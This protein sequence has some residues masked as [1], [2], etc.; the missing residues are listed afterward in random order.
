MQ[1]RKDQVQAY[2]FVVGRLAAAVTHGRP[3]VLQPPNKR[4]NSGVVLGFMLAAV[5]AGIFGVYG[6]FVP[7][8]DNT[9]QSQ[10]AIVMDESTG[11]RY[12]YLDGQLRPVLNYSSARLASGNAG[13][14][15]VI[16]VSRNSLKNTPI[17]QPIGIP[18]APDALPDSGKLVDPA[19]TECIQPGGTVTLL[20]GE[21][22]DKPDV[23]AAHGIVVATPD[24]GVYL[25]WQG[26]RY[27]VGERTVLETLGYGAVRPVPVVPSWLNPIPAGPDI[28]L[29][30]VPG[31]GTSGPV[32][33]GRPSRVGQVYKIHNAALGFDQLYLVG[34]DA[35]SSL[36]RTG[37]ALVLASPAAK[38]AYRDA[39]VRPIEAGPG[40][41]SG[42]PV[43]AGP[44][45]AAGLPADP[46]QIVTPSQTDS[47]CVSFMPSEHSAMSAAVE[48][49]PAS[50]VAARSVPAAAHRAGET[51]DRVGVPAGAGVLAKELLAPG[52]VPGTLYLVTEVGI[53]FPLAD[54][55]VAGSLGYPA[56]SAVLVPRELLDLLPTGPVLSASGA[57]QPQSPQ[58]SKTSGS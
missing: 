47:P 28:T 32:I 22:R 26:K 48:F 9:W 49:R 6:L 23:S 33:D 14:G 46:P 1:S 56:S 37:A 36:S 16:S 20:L 38:A 29:P 53:R 51:A 5:L 7:G 40:A 43:S 58:I 39:E 42:I 21:V 55:G 8:G 24:G 2:F 17:G 31:A 52:A 57:V 44:D 35:V 15:S 3:D 45:F 27:R 11:A 12:V 41:L 13:G 30:Q 10:G 4:T 18:G 25:L 54:A 34:S 50:Q 19:W